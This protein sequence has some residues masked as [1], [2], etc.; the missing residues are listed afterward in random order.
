MLICFAYQACYTSVVGG[1][2]SSTPAFL[3]TQFLAIG[4]SLLINLSTRL[5]C[6]IPF[7]AALLLTHIWAYFCG[8]PVHP[9]CIERQPIDIAGV[10]E[11]VAF[12]E[13]K[14][15]LAFGNVRRTDQRAAPLWH[16]VCDPGT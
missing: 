11:V 12:L 5:V 1:C 8:I 3:V 9:V 2:F 6:S 13:T 4:S 15:V 7:P 16:A 14:W 10:C